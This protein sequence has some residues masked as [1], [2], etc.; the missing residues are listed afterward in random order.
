LR[1]RKRRMMRSPVPEAI[2]TDIWSLAYQAIDD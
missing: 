2:Y 1:E